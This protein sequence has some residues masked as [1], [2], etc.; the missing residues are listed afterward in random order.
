MSFGEM[1]A[2]CSEAHKKHTNTLCGQF[3]MLQLA[4]YKFTAGLS[5]IN[6]MIIEK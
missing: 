5:M 3:I 1:A 2:V 6:K 4:V